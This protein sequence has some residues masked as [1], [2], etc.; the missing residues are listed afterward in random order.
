MTRML[1]EAGVAIV[2]VSDGFRAKMESQMRQAMAGAKAEVPVSANMRAAEAQLAKYATLAGRTKAA[3]KVTAD[4]GSAERDLARFEAALKAMSHP[5]VKLD[6]DMTKVQ[7]DSATAMAYI[8]KLKEAARTGLKLNSDT[9]ETQAK[10]GVLFATLEKLQK[11]ARNIK[12]DGDVAP[13]MSKIATVWTAIKDMSR[14]AREIHMNAD[15]T[16]LKAEVAQG[17]VMA[18]TLQRDLKSMAMGVDDA[19]MLR[20]LSASIAETNVLSAKL[21]NLNMDGDATPFLLKLKAAT[22]E[23]H[24]LM[25]TMT[26]PAA[27]NLIP[28]VDVSRVQAFSDKLADA[29]NAYNV[30]NRKA[31]EAASTAALVD[32]E[33]AAMRSDR[34]AD[35]ASAYN[36]IT[37]SAVAAAKAQD[38]MVNREQTLI[39]ALKNSLNLRPQIVGQDVQNFLVNTVSKTEMLREQLKDLRANVDDVRAKVAL[40]DLMARVLAIQDR[41]ANL[42]PHASLS[43]LLTD[44]ATLE[45]VVGKASSEFGNLDGEQKSVFADMAGV[46]GMAGRMGDRLVGAGRD[47]TNSFNLMGGAVGNFL[48]L[49]GRVT[50]FGGAFNKLNSYLLSFVS[51][52]HLLAD[53]IFEVIA[54]WVPATVAFA[55]WA[56]AAA[57]VVKGVVTQFQNMGTAVAATGKSLNNF[58]GETKLFSDTMQ[59]AVRPAVWQLVGDAINVVNARSGAFVGFLKQMNPLVDKL[60]ARATVALKN[61]FGNFL[62][63][64]AKMFYQLGTAIGNFLGILGNLGKVVPH[65]AE[66]LLGLGT[67]F[68]KI[69]EDITGSP[70][71]QAI[72]GLALKF[73]GAAVYLGVFIT[74]LATLGRSLLGGFLQGLAGARAKMQE[75]A[76]S[77]REATAATGQLDAA[78]MA[79]AG[80]MKNAEG[81]TTGLAGA[82]RGLGTNTQEGEKALKDAGAASEDT[83]G[84][85]QK[86]GSGLGALVGNMG[87]LGQKSVGAFKSLDEG[88]SVTSRMGSLVKKAGSGLLGMASAFTGLGPVGLGVMAG[89]AVGAGILY[90]ALH[91]VNNATQAWVQ[92]QQNLA[93]SAPLADYLQAAKNSYAQIQVKVNAAKSAIM[94][95]AETQ[96][97]A[98]RALKGTNMTFQQANSILQG[99]VKYGRGAAISAQLLLQHYSDLQAGLNQLSGQ[100][101]AYNRGIAIVTKMTGSQTAAIGLLNAAGITTK[102]LIADQTAALHGNSGAWQQDMVMIQGTLVGFQAMSPAIGGAASAMNALTLSTSNTLSEVQKVTQAYTQFIGMVTGSAQQFAQFQQGMSTLATS[103][104]PPGAAGGAGGGGG[105]GGSAGTF[106]FQNGKVNASQPV[107]GSNGVI[108]GVTQAGA[109]SLAAYV[110]QVQQAEQLMNSLMTQAALAGNTKGAN[111]ASSKAAKDVV[112]MLGAV[113]GVKGNPAATSM[114]GALAQTGGYSGATTDFKGITQWAGNASGATADLNKQMNLLTVASSNL[115]QDVGRLS[116]TM[117][118]QLLNA[119]SNAIMAAENMGPKLE[120]LAKAT[121]AWVKAGANVGGQ[122]WNQM[123]K[124]AAPVAQAFLMQTHNVGQARLSL[125]AYLEQMGVS[126]SVATKMADALIKGTSATNHHAAAARSA[127]AAQRLVNNTLGNSIHAVAG[128]ATAWQNFAVNG[129][130]M[131]ARQ[132]VNLWNKLGTSGLTKLAHEAGGSKHSFEQLAEKLGFTAA[133][134][135]KMWKKFHQQDLAVLNTKVG[136]SY[137]DFM[138]FAHALGLTTSAAQNLWAKA[139]QQQFDALSGKSRATTRDISSLAH[140]FG[141]SGSNASELWRIM[142]KEYISAVAGKASLGEKAFKHWAQSVGISKDKANELWAML[143]HQYLDTLANK[144]HTAYG[145]FIK[146]AQAMGIVASKAS[147]MW[148]QAHQQQFDMLSSKSHATANQIHNLAHQFGI[149]TGA[150]STLWG[151]MHQQYLDALTGKA[152]ITKKSFDNWARSVHMSTGEANTLWAM[153][154]Q[155]Y[156]DV[157][158]GK[159]IT[160]RSTFMKLSDS[161]HIATGKANDMWGVLRQ[162]YLDVIHHKALMSRDAFDKLAQK[163]GYSTSQANA[164]WDKLKK[165]QGTY[166]VHVKAKVDGGGKVGAT[167]TVSSALQKAI[168]A[169]TAVSGIT[170]GSNTAPGVSAHHAQGGIATQVPGWGNH[171]SVHAMLMPGELIIPKNHAAEFAGMAKRKGIPGFA[172][173]GIV[174]NSDTG[175]MGGGGLNQAQFSGN[176]GEMSAEGS[177]L[178]QIP[179]DLTSELSKLQPMVVNELVSSIQA[180]QQNIMG[181]AGGIPSGVVSGAEMANLFTIARYLMSQGVAKG[182][183]AGIASVIAGESAGNPESVGSGGFGLIG[184]TGNTSGLPAGYHGPTGNASR[185]L[186]IQMAG[187]VGYGRANG[188]WS[189]LITMNDPVAAG[190][191]WSRQF[192]RPAVALS[193]T[194]PG[195]AQQIFTQLGGVKG[196]VQGPMAP[197]STGGGMRIL[198]DAERYLGHRYRWGGPSN[199]TTGWDCSSFVSWVLGHDLGMPL[200]GGSWASVTNSGQS[201]GPVA[202]AFANLP[203]ATP[204]G[205]NPAMIAPGDVLVWPGHVGFGV[206]PNKMFSAYGTNFGTIFSNAQAA[207][208]LTIMRPG[209]GGFGMAGPPPPVS[210]T[211]AFTFNFAEGGIVGDAGAGGSKGAGRSLSKRHKSVPHKHAPGP[212]HKP[213]TEAQQIA[214]YNAMLA[215]VVAN[216][217]QAVKLADAAEKQANAH[218]LTAAEKKA[219]LAAAAKFTSEA[220]TRTAKTPHQKQIMAKANSLIADAHAFKVGEAEHKKLLAIAANDRFAASNA[221]VTAK[222]KKALLHEA[223]VLTQA[224]NEPKFSSTERK[225]LM[226]EATHLRDQ[227][228]FADSRAAR[229]KL[230]GEAAAKERAAHAA[231]GSLRKAQEYLGQAHVWE[232]RMVNLEHL[233]NKKFHK[234]ASSKLMKTLQADAQELADLNILQYDPLLRTLRAD[235]GIIKSPKL[236]DVLKTAGGAVSADSRAR[237]AAASSAAAPL[238]GVNTSLGAN[239]TRWSADVSKALAMEGLPQSLMNQVLFQISTES[240]GNPTAI[241]LWD[242]NA[243][244]GHPSQGLLQTIPS[245]FKSFHWPGTSSNIDDPLA[246]IAAAINYARHKYGPRLMTGGMGLGSGRGYALGGIIPEPVFG[247]GASGRQYSFGERGPERILPGTT[248]NGGAGEPGMTKYQ[249]AT[250]ICLLQQLVTVNRQQPQQLGQAMQRGSG[251]S[252]MSGFTPLGR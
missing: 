133:Q 119:E 2:P 130:G 17:I 84:K 112:A 237:N 88:A 247:I 152:G 216:Y 185:D 1:G 128:S 103:L 161:W 61:G 98:G 150:A 157:I 211:G 63:G 53:A 109:A 93:Q 141:I 36:K 68:L 118:T 135:D 94:N 82:W 190:N 248:P 97:A 13:L 124:A 166:G 173:G 213:P 252:A 218:P 154:H 146:L 222:Q 6:S 111:F 14:D 41:M 110:Q 92:T 75:Y 249:A 77:T 231:P 136:Q 220:D 164:L 184:W 30:M 122:G 234:F 149:S 70:L 50:L 160:T 62:S 169:G 91:H 107:Q 127:A 251:R 16:Q 48:H 192:E 223:A 132:A 194:R 236:K 10:F 87:N 145:A 137:T 85:M 90:L 121:M 207:G 151:M 76:A 186:A 27:I 59:Q 40:D 3:V 20:K 65:Y 244:A 228:P 195:I 83:R 114:L 208:G 178:I 69:V 229:H 22:M 183:A 171:D 32:R 246:N 19:A 158:V 26:R 55:A 33:A 80:K 29:A 42:S 215:K 167:V 113:P 116:Q 144:S 31:R 89:L 47:T 159:A 245:T 235:T 175:L 100:T 96:T 71:F 108:G 67:A 102:Q 226:R 165:M 182:A 129:L 177:K 187:I 201:H 214:A 209:G 242:S 115:N 99:Q 9:G 140:Q 148:A 37:L 18:K 101:E 74:L 58:K 188:P 230:L 46:A 250:M 38:A 4:L 225:S 147:I 210:D 199:P 126:Q 78:T 56:A 142:H 131:T 11:E 64:G 174:G 125:E 25:D 120:N 54:V 57:P 212:H 217:D 202:S 172:S 12:S 39:N 139:H 15:A 227:L 104:A 198:S 197:G 155:Q 196:G 73:H 123:M 179:A 23:A 191:L 117:N 239:V 224:A 51:G 181:L 21:R 204:V 138:H 105:K 162:Q 153:L 35:A 44:F 219:D 168:N 163:F 86:L 232:T 60:G 134:A 189:Q 243:K 28:T 233:M 176:P 193:D 49:M 52:W 106:T 221:K 7:R 24:A 206:G 79:G 72:A 240:S 8:E 241:N 200:P 205:H 180:M 34:L 238:Q 170:A 143:K 156:F 5:K 81:A 203:G 66:I 43:N 45:R 95:Y